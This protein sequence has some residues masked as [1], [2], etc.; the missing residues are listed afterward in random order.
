M[1]SILLSG[2]FLQ[3]ANA[4]SLLS[5]VLTPDASKPRVPRQSRP[6]YDPRLTARPLYERL[7]YDRPSRCGRCDDSYDD[8]D[9]PRDRYD[10]DRR[11]SHRPTYGNKVDRSRGGERDEEG[12][13]SSHSDR[14]SG[15]RKNGTDPTSE[16]GEKKQ[17][18]DKDRPDGGERDRG[19]STFL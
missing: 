13:Y 8:Y 16:E 17:Y 5:A 10:D 19:R 6:Y 1:T 15:E 14:R 9:R 4:E 11:L 7:E 3:P 12:R 2:S 18:D